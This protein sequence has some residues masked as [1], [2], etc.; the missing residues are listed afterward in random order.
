MLV[1][2]KN[3]PQGFTI[4]ELL[5]VIVVIAIL[6]A[7]SVVAYSG[8]QSR[9][10]AA[11]IQS[12]LATAKKKLLI[13]QADNGQFPATTANLGN[14]DISVTR[15]A[16]DTTGNNL[17]YCYNK[18]TGQFALA[19]RTASTKTSYIITSTGSLQT[20]GTSTGDVTCQAAGLTGYNDPDA[21]YTIGFG[22]GHG[23][24]GWVGGS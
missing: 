24:Y 6:A 19:A 4:V 20:I 12:D 22:P 10:Q 18:I 11:V 3:Y 17:Y 13:Y 23:W 14:A 15:S 2:S 7:I 21:G 5:I 9:A 16:Y 8:L 1:R